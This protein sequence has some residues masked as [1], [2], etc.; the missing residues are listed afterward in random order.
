MLFRT[1][2]KISEDILWNS[3][4]R[5]KTKLYMRCLI[6]VCKVLG[7]QGTVWFRFFQK[8][9]VLPVS[10]QCHM[11]YLFVG[12]HDGRPMGQQFWQNLTWPPSCWPSMS[13]C[14]PQ[15]PF[16]IIS[17]I[18]HA[19]NISPFHRNNRTHMYQCFKC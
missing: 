4:P 3:N 19:M 10:R 15:N 2:A 18:S 17:C 5:K 8:H 16:P 7:Q 9:H 11:V 1:I 12:R 13:R 6:S 14:H